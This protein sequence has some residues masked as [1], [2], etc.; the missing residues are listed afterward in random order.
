MNVEVVGVCGRE[1][2]CGGLP[3]EL[4]LVRGDGAGVCAVLGALR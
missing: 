4:Q 1:G 2:E 3:T